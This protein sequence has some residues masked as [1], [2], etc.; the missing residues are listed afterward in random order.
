MTDPAAPG[1]YPPPG[2]GQT[3]GAY[4]AP[5]QF[6]APGQAPGQ[7][8]A[9]GQDP[10]P[11]QYQPPGQYPGAAPYPPAAPGAPGGYPPP[12]PYGAPPPAAP[13]KKKSNVLRIVLIVVGV[14][15]VLC[16]AGIF[17]L[18][19]FVGNALENTYEVG[20]CLTAM[21]VTD[22]E[23]VYRG[24]VVSC[25]SADA[26]ARIVEVHDGASLAQAD[27]LCAGA[28]GYVAAVAVAI[29]NN[30]RLLCLAEV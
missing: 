2:Q 15:V 29:G 19:K 12:P 11:G 13:P 25:D 10:V 30:S 8:P 23:T 27:Q 14:A 28:P 20:N 22:V 17:A 6:P 5:G 1:A 7:F 24:S 9:S 4:P 3:P 21:P 16:A 26:E 18:V